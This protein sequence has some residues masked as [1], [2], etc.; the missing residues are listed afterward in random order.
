M[1]MALVLRLPLLE[2]NGV[3]LEQGDNVM[4]DKGFKIGDL[5][6]EHGITLNIPPFV[7]Q[8]TIRA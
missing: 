7:R 6:T 2:R 5:L 3:D 8:T 4:A 1:Y